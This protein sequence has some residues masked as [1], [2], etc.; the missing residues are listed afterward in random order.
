M[1][2]STAFPGWAGPQIT[3]ARSRLDIAC[4]SLIHA[5]YTVADGLV[6]YKVGKLVPEREAV[7][8]E[9][10]GIEAPAAPGGP[11]KGWARS[12]RDRTG[13][14]QLG[15]TLVQKSGQAKG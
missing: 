13:V 12:G 1:T 7:A 8:K 11:C 10:L 6:L 14:D 4:Y 2:K 3:A 9:A 5:S 15:H